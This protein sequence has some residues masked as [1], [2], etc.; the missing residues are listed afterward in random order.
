MRWDV[1][2][3][4][5]LKCSLRGEDGLVLDIALSPKVNAAAALSDGSLLLW[6]LQSGGSRA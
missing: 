1:A 6:D 3:G 4:K 5:L 2:S